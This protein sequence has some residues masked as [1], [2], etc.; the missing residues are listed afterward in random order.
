M[1]LNAYEDGKDIRLRAISTID[2]YHRMYTPASAGPIELPTILSSVFNPSDMPVNS[3]GVASSVTFR[4]PTFV[5]DNPVDSI[6]RPAET[7]IQLPWNAR[8]KK[9]P[10]AVIEVPIIIGL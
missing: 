10:A 1:L 8:R 5:S 6:A 4:A 9:N 2:W 3:A 7:A